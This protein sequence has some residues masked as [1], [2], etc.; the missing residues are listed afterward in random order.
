MTTLQILCTSIGIY[1]IV[2]SG[3]QA[4]VMD[5]GDKL[6][7]LVKYALVLYCSYDLIV[8]YARWDNFW[9]GMT[10]ASFFWKRNF[11]RL[12][13]YYNSKCKKKH[14]VCSVIIE[15]QTCKGCKYHEKES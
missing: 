10:I 11:D 4:I 2:E 7:R 5:N 15:S 1:L 3:I 6:C 9:F 14:L 12:Q 13:A 8:G